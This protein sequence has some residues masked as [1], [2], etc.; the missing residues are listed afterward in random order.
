[1][2]K[3]KKAKAVKELPPGYYTCTFDK[4]QVKKDGRVFLKKIRII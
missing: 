1:M 3:K 4:V 2:G